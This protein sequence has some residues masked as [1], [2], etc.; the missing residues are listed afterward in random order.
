MMTQLHG[1]F[2]DDQVKV[3]LREYC[4]RLLARAEIHVILDIGKAR[5]PVLFKEYRKDWEAFSVA[6]QRPTPGRWPAAIEVEIER[7][8]L[9]EKEIVEDERLPISGYNYPAM[10]VHL[11]KK[12][13]EVS[14]TPNID[15]CERADCQKPREK[16]K[17]HDR[18]M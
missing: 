11:K 13:I 6:F 15:R 9:R 16:R 1:W 2:T 12:D 14:V 18:E 5:V 4:Q 7:E 8:L 17:S 10:Q 3:P